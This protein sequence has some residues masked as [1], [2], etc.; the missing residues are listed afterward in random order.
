MFGFTFPSSCD[1]VPIVM[2][3]RTHD[4]IVVW[5]KTERTLITLQEVVEEH[6]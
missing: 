2:P 1:H 4:D 6:L 5:L 3:T